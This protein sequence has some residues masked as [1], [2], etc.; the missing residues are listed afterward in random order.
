MATKRRIG[1]ALIE[2]LELPVDTSA[3]YNAADL[4]ISGNAL[5]ATPE[6][7]AEMPLVYNASNQPLTE[8]P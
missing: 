8:A 4:Q 7:L 2:T 3:T 5:I 6:L 1:D